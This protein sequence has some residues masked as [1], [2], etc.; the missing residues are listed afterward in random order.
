MALDP[1]LAS[2]RGQPGF[3][4][5]VQELDDAISKMHQRVLESEQ[6]GNWDAL[7]ALVDNT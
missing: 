5:M 7:R 2:L 3:E 6:K 1:Y 4:A